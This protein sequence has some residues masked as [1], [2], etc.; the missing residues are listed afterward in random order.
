MCFFPRPIRLKCFLQLITNKA[1]NLLKFKNIFHKFWL[2]LRRLFSKLIYF[3]YSTFLSIRENSILNFPV[4]GTTQICTFS[5]FRFYKKFP[6]SPKLE[7]WD[8]KTIKSIDLESL[9][10]P[11]WAQRVGNSSFFPPAQHEDKNRASW[12][13]NRLSPGRS[14]GSPPL[15]LL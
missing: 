11:R 7:K 2:T 4:F 15:P 8:T 12:A 14:N 9:P 10:K 13:P 5:H 3:Y 6:I 1:V